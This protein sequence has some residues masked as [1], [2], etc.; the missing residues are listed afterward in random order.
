MNEGSAGQDNLS[1]ISPDNKIT[2]GGARRLF[3]KAVAR[4]SSIK[5]LLRHRGIEVSNINLKDRKTVLNNP[6]IAEIIANNGEKTFLVHS[7]STSEADEIMDSGLVIPNEGEKLEVS[8]TAFMLAGPSM[9]QRAL[10]TLFMTYRYVDKNTKVIAAFPEKNPG[11]WNQTASSGAVFDP[12]EGTFLDHKDGKYIIENT[13]P[14]R[15]DYQRFKISNKY[16]L[17]YINI[18]TGEFVRNADYNEE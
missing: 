13:D 11:T 14:M 17:G 12:F 18:D 7:A 9:L 4:F 3:E 5:P 8:H 1:N 16:I 10:N 2:E 15:S 6:S